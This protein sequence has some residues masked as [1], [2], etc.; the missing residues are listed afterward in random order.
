MTATRLRESLEPPLFKL[1][2]IAGQL[3]SSTAVS[4][5]VLTDYCTHLAELCSAA[6]HQQVRGLTHIA[7]L[8]DS[9]LQKISEDKFE[10]DA[11]GRATL[12]NWP[13]LV[14]AEI[15]GLGQTPEPGQWAVLNEL[16]QHAWFPHLPDYFAEL[17]ETRLGEDLQRFVAEEPIVLEE[18]AFLEEEPLALGDT[19]SVE[20]EPAD[21]GEVLALPEGNDDDQQ[22]GKVAPEELEML[23]EALVALQEEFKS[24]FEARPQGEAL[25]QLAQQY[26]EQLANI[27]NA[28]DHLGLEGLQNVIGTIQ[29]NAL[30][31]Q[32]SNEQPDPALYALLA[33]WPTQAVTYLAAPNDAATAQALAEVVTHAAWPH[34]ASAEIIAQWVADLTAVQ[35]V[36]VRS[37]PQRALV[38]LPEHMDLTVPSDIDSHVLD[39]LLVELPR[40]SQEFTALVQRLADGGSMNDVDSARRV[41]HTLKGA[42]NTVGVKG[43]GNLTHV[44]ED[45]L[46]ACEREQKLPSPQ[47]CE[48]LI[49]AAD[50]LEEMSEALLGKGDAPAQSVAVYQSV[51]DWANRIDNEG[52]PEAGIEL[53]PTLAPVVALAAAPATPAASVKAPEVEEGAAEQDAESYLRVAASLVDSQLNLVGEDSIIMSQLQDRITKL[54]DDLNAQRIG[55]RH[56]RQLSSEL[57]QLVDVRGMAMMGGGSGELDALEMDQYNE[58]HMLSRRIVEA[59]ADTH[60]FSMAFEREVAGLRDLMA[61]KERVQIDMQQSLQR[62]RM[63]DVASVTPRLQRTVRQATRMLK[64]PVQLHI[65]GESTLVDTHLLDNMLN[66]LMHMLRNA[67]DHGIESADARLAL[68][69]PETGTITLSFA[70]EGSNL[71]VRCEDDGGGLDVEAIRTKA[72]QSG[73]ITGNDKLTETQVMRLILVPGFSTRDQATMMSGR[74][75]GMDVVQRAVNDLRGSLELNSNSGV[76]SRF[77]LTFPVNLSSA[78]VLISRSPRHL[79]AISERR[80]DQLLPLGD[81]LR[82]EADGSLTYLLHDQRIPAHR[83]EHLL[84]LPT[85]AL[86]HPGMNE[87]AMIVRDENRQWQAII[88]PEISESRSVV[89]KPFNALLPR[90]AGVDGV[91]ILGD[92]SIASVIDL[93]DLLRSAQ[94]SND[95][96]I[97]DIAA[98]EMV[99]P[100][101][102]VVDD[103]VSVR[104]TME[105]LMQDTGYEVLSARDGLDALGVLQRRV[106][107]IVLVDLEMPRMNGLELTSV[108]RSRAETQTT[109]V[110][111]ITSRF[112]EKHHQ[113][114]QR[115][116]VSAFLTKPYSEE[117]LLQIMEG[118]LREQTEAQ[119]VA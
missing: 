116:G 64:K 99:L 98:P 111:M 41:A 90:A 2:E 1:F 4:A 48:T 39:S 53:T 3:E 59:S 40:H 80:V 91:T 75:I 68:G 42:G 54:T 51:L 15:M 35:V 9:G 32:D 81:N 66:P 13:G 50:C 110:V 25:A 114:A 16:R 104:R 26:A 10:L 43:V 6:K 58:L 70:T 37:G 18:E 60:E 5:T 55:S 88:A 52:L 83:L 33:E 97:S 19:A 49:E 82:T 45:I 65:L 106:P 100:L 117:K 14:L 87:V 24:P 46:V 102:L 27:L 107:D 85:T 7:T 96:S 108:L 20:I 61:A 30:T 95:A 62:T 47:L 109:P 101:C 73:L 17:L 71:V 86:K 11:A 79:L 115:A 84:R 38:A 92:G 72:V 89:V 112:T 94:D 8:L 23:S 103:S 28:A 119:A 118:L 113:L 31:L 77:D 56:L 69:K 93:P 74:G 63:V 29:I 44:L 34:P 76:G 36:T 105:R 22:Q 12:A 21:E 57:E 67:V 78:K